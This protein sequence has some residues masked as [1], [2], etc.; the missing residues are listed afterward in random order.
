MFH[1]ILKNQTLIQ[2]NR[3]KQRQADNILLSD[4]P[5]A[6]H[7]QQLTIRASCVYPLYG[8]LSAL[9]LQ[10]VMTC[11]FV[12]LKVQKPAIITSSQW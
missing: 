11:K 4:D 8:F 7:V 6:I 2:H 10:G 3:C 9:N 12:Q 5:N 1:R